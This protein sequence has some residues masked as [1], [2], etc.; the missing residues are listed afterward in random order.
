VYFSQLL[1][2]R[3]LDL[4]LNFPVGIDTF[5][6]RIENGSRNLYACLVEKLNQ[7][8]SLRLKCAVSALIS[9]VLILH[10]PQS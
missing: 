4:A 9:K 2:V 8:M 1:I 7:K 6:G 10:F 3:A 5:V